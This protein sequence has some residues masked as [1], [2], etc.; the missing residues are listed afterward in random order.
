MEIVTESIWKSATRSFMRSLMKILGLALGLGIIVIALSFFLGNG[1]L[2]SPSIPTLLP[3]A[4]GQRKLLPMHTPAIAV[5]RIDNIIGLGDLTTEKINN[6]LLDTRTGILDHDRLKGILLY[7]NSPG[8]TAIDSD[9]IYRALIQYKETYKIPIFTYIDGLCASGGY[10]IACASDKI[11]ASPSSIIGSVGVRFGPMFNFTGTME[12][13][14]VSSL[15]LTQ[16]KD[17]DE[18]NSFRPWTADEGASLSPIT[19]ALYERFVD[20]VAK[21]RP[22]LDR[23]ALINTYGA[24]VF[25][26]AQAHQYNYIDDPDSTYEKTLEALA[27]AAGIDTADAYQVIQLSPSTS[28]IQQ[29]SQARWENM[30]RNVLG[31]PDQQLQ[32]KFLLM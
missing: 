7:I 4:Q 11:S 8:G 25:I 23:T 6:L 19:Y 15:T 5:I 21:A 18:F 32:G 26:A 24:K 13:T 9:N 17:K 10:Y 3:D 27:Q 30:M 20:I 1:L 28:L 31:L 14:G 16:G 2:P 22:S 12:K 29:F